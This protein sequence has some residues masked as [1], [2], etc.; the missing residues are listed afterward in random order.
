MVSNFA[1]AA[2][3]R[4]QPR[5][6][7]GSSGGGEWTSDRRQG[8]SAGARPGRN[9]SLAAGVQYVSDRLAAD[10]DADKAGS[11]GDKPKAY[12]ATDL[13]KGLGTLV[14]S[15]Q[16]TDYV[17]SVTPGLPRYT[18][19]WRPGTAITKDN[20]D[21]IKPGTAIASFSGD[22]IY[23][24]KSGENH[25]A[26]YI[27]PGTDDYGRS[28]IRVQDQWVGRPVKEH[29][30]PFDANKGVNKAQNFSVVVGR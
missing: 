25:A 1:G 27:G 20:L 24:N 16:C 28:G 14:G 12:I 30:I 17:E 11:D 6:P 15:G 2:W 22:G 19:D 4:D 29:V 18:S 13:K 26:I 21:Q 5:V 23:H 3:K 9:A 8:K 10:D 7:K